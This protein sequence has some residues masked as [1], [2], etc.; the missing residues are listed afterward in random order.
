MPEIEMTSIWK[1]GIVE[2]EAG[3]QR[4]D[5]NDTKFFTTEAEAKAYASRWEEGG[6]S[7]C[8][9]RATITRVA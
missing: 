5:P 9:W 8:Y 4:F 7:E 3:I 1:V 6:S 2:Y